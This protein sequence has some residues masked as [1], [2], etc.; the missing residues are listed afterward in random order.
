MSHRTP[1]KLE[2]KLKPT[3]FAL[4]TLHFITN[5]LRDARHGIGKSAA[6]LDAENVF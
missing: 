6:K 3:N 1:E 4:S 5:Y 2:K